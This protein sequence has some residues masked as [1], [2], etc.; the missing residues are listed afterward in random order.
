MRDL[1][2]AA[3]LNVA[4]LYHYFPSKRD[5][6]ES[7]L[8]R[9]GVPSR[10]G[11]R[12]DPTA[13]SPED[14]TADPGPAPGRDHDLHVRGGGLRPPH[15]GRGHPRRG[16]RP[17]RRRRPVRLVRDEHRGL[18]HAATV[19]TSTRDRAPPRWPGSSAPWWSGSS[20]STPPTCSATAGDDLT[21]LSLDRAR[22]AAAVLRVQSARVGALDGS[23]GQGG[24][25]APHPTAA[26]TAVASADFAT[27]PAETV[28][29]YR[30]DFANL[31][32]YNPDVSGVE[33]RV[34]DGDGRRCRRNPGP[35][36]PLH[37]RAGRPAPAGRQPSGRAVDGRGRGA[38]AGR[39][40]DVGR[41]RGLRGV[42]GAAARRRRVRGDAD[43]VG[44]AA[45]RP[46]P[47]TC[48]AAAAGGQPGLRSAKSSAS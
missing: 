27:V 16:D 37:L 44:H 48:V 38:D 34:A 25:C 42:R 21:A 35:R 4:S 19:P 28:W 40:R 3:G 31:P 24:A 7:V 46:A 5:L 22:E 45:R 36:G 47:T 32:E 14:R 20:S 41:Q 2:S 6:L 13:Q 30:L 9:A 23:S 15:G 33:R 12:T 43:P 1:A 26:P 29:A 10:S 8:D 18:G 11:R 39:R 17:R